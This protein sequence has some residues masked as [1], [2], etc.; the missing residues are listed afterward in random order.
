MG[1]ETVVREKEEGLE[2]RTSGPTRM[3]EGLG[4]WGETR[5]LVLTFFHWGECG[6]RYSGVVVQLDTRW[7]VPKHQMQVSRCQHSVIVWLGHKQWEHDGRSPENVFSLDY[8]LY[9]KKKEEKNFNLNKTFNLLLLR[10]KEIKIKYNWV[11]WI[12]IMLIYMKIFRAY[13]CSYLKNK[14]K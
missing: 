14:I 12:M 10:L 3:E 5:L 11:L 6:G 7:P 1:R 8:C 13:S 4:E 9:R 2:W